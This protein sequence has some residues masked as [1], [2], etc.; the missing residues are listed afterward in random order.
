MS[1][2]SIRLTPV[3]S[4]ITFSSGHYLHTEEAGVEQENK[5]LLGVIEKM[6]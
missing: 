3:I 6:R 2:R 5:R 1:G 4:K